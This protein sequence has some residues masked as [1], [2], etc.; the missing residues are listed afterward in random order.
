MYSSLYLPYKL[1][2]RQEKQ[3]QQ[4]QQLVKQMKTGPQ[5]ILNSFVVDNSD[6]RER[7]SSPIRSVSPA[8]HL[9]TMN[10]SSSA[11]DNKAV[12]RSFVDCQAHEPTKS[13]NVHRTSSN[14]QAG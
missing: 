9:S 13:S 1:W 8:K 7:A 14:L 6:T 4:E 11:V 12:E 5:S 10:Q 3:R 2:Q